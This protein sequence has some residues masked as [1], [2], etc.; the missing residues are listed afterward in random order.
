[1][2]TD[3]LRSHFLQVAG[4]YLKNNPA[5][6]RALRVEFA[7]TTIYGG[8]HP[9][10]WDLHEIT[11]LA[12]MAGDDIDIMPMLR[13]R[14]IMIID[15][16]LA[17]RPAPPAIQP[18]PARTG[19]QGKTGKVDLTSAAPPAQ[20]KAADRAADQIKAALK[21]AGIDWTTLKVQER[22]GRTAGAKVAAM[23]GLVPPMP[24]DAFRRGWTAMNKDLRD[25][26]R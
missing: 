12:A 10:L 9:L 25:R 22:G 1:M 2:D 20:R 19:A 16:W 24:R 11:R 4:E 14:V 13:Q 8:Y 5:D 18:L 23:R 6:L 21:V 26:I 17:R 7:G 15:A 3:E